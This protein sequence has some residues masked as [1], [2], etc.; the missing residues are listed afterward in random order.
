MKKWY[1]HTLPHLVQFCVHGLWRKWGG[2]E[3]E[4]WIGTRNQ[5]DHPDYVLF[6]D[7]SRCQTN[8][9]HDGNVGN[10]KFIV[11]QDTRPQIICSTA[12]HPFSILPFTSGL[13]EIACCMLIFQRK[14]EEVPVTLKTVISITVENPIHNKK[15]E[16]DFELNVGESK[17]YSEGLKCKYRGKR[18]IVLPLH[19]RVV[20]SLV[21]FL[22]KYLSTL[23][24]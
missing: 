6:A 17:Y 4:V 5:I 1:M 20:E 21:P 18:W 13:G 19:P 11:E 10:R 22:S 16:I 7:E 2:R 14:E 12:N 24:C 9:K 15:G 23:T 8:Q 3:W